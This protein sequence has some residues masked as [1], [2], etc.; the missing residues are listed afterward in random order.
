M[1][2][3]QK[4]FGVFMIFAITGCADPNVEPVVF[5]LTTTDHAVAVGANLR[6]V[7]ETNRTIERDGSESRPVT[8]SEANPD[9]IV[10]FSRSVTGAV[11]VAEPNGPQGSG[12]ATVTSNELAQDLGGRSAGVLALR[13]GLSAACQA[14]ANGIIGQ[15][16]YALILSQYGSLLVALAGTGGAGSAPRF[17]AQ[18]AAISALLVSCI[19]E[20]DDTR[21]GSFHKNPLLSEP[22]CKRLID[23]IAAGKLLKPVLERA[24]GSKSAGMAPPD[25]TMTTNN[26]K[27]T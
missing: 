11:N 8:C 4:F 19:S 23:L 26:G 18:E 2:D 21:L 10:A 13:D 5:H 12:T 9:A 3:V 22:R 17:T 14:Y 20:H 7:T 24:S 1:S 16:A 15:D 25:G 27:P 6:I